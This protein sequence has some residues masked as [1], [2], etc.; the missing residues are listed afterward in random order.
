M[1][2]EGVRWLSAYPKSAFALVVLLLVTL[3]ALSQTTS[4]MAAPVPAP[5]SDVKP[6]HLLNA[7][8]R[9]I[10]A[11]PALFYRNS[12]IP[13]GVRHSLELT[14]ALAHDRFAKVHY[15]NFDAAHAYIVHVKDPRLVHVSYRIGDEIYWTK[16]ELRLKTGETLLTDGKSFVRTRCGNRIADTPQSKVSDREPAPEEFDVVI[17]PP[18]VAPVNRT[19]TP[20][21]IAGS[22]T[23]PFNGPT[24][25]AENFVPTTGTEGLIPRPP[26]RPIHQNEHPVPPIVWDHT[27]PLSPFPLPPSIE[28]PD[29][30]P[31]QVPEPASF[32]LV[33]LALFSLLLIR[34][35]NQQK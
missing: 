29:D 10:S 28:L 11:P 2:N 8:A 18:R 31:T 23:A 17:A 15:A 35:R 30:A 9:I 19:P 1:K 21:N 24:T 34:R 26:E 25:N 32:A 7:K 16:K 20:T 6:A 3:V 5:G 12:V 33:M 14:S 13:G 27:P 22:H 4:Q